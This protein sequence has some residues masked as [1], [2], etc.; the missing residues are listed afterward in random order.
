[1][2]R[3]PTVTVWARVTPRIHRQLD[4]VARAHGL[5]RAA[6]IAR[7]ITEAIHIYQAEH[8]RPA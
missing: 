7:L 8:V 3:E 4:R 2:R 5:T 6:L 1:M